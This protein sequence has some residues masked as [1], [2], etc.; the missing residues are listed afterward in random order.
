M[1]KKKEAT[2]YHLRLRLRDMPYNDWFV[3]SEQKDYYFGSIAAIYEQFTA[4]EIGIQASSLYNYNF[5]KHPFYQNDE[6]FIR[7]GQLITKQQTKTL[8][9]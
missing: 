3:Q 9:L 7:K 6:C 5:N 2:V 1:K 8:T 4:K